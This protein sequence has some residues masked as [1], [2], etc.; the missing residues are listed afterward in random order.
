[1]S[2]RHRI[3]EWSYWHIDRPKERLL[4]TLAARLPRKLKERVY[5]SVA[6]EAISK[7]PP[8]TVVPEVGMLEALDVYSNGRVR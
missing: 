2:L 3:R 1:M 4:V 7:M 5:I 8:D 6:V